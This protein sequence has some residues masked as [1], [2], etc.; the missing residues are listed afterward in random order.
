MSTIW[1][2]SHYVGMTCCQRFAAA[3]APNFSAQIGVSLRLGGTSFLQIDTKSFWWDNERDSTF[4]QATKVRLMA[5][6]R[7]GR[8]HHPVGSRFRVNSGQKPR[9]LEIGLLLRLRR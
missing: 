4:L 9:V 6:G 2:L 1:F 8:F 5:V 3:S 7:D